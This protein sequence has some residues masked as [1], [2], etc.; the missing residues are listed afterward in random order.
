MGKQ[1]VQTT[2]APA[3]IGPYAQAVVVDGW[4][5]CSGQIPLD[6]A[7]GEL[8]AGDVTAQTR[9]VLENL[10]AV[11]AAAGCSLADVVKTTIYLTNLAHFA[12]VNAVYAEYFGASPPARATV[13][14]A[15]LPRGA[16]VEIE[17]VARPGAGAAEG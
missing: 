8:V 15:A 17:A 7:T 11:L 4:V 13:G 9:R 12:Q 5:Y 3:A 2:A 14:V 16:A 1:T 6:P 10:K